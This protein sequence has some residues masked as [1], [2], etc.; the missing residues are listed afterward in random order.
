MSVATGMTGSDHNSRRSDAG[1]VLALDHRLH[2][3]IDITANPD[4]GL[5]SE[6]TGRRVDHGKN[7]KMNGETGSQSVA[8]ALM[9]NR[10]AMR[11]TRVL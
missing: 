7:G 3:R 1:A 5:I 6:E 9:V 8:S 4:A 10:L 11:P 2:V